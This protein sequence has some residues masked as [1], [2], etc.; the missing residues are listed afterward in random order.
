[1]RSREKYKYTPCYCEE[2][3]WHLC[4]D[5]IGYD[6]KAV[7]ISNEN[8]QCPMWNQR[9]AGGEEPVI[10]DYHVIYLSSI[11]NQ[12]MI[13]DLDTTLEFPSKPEV[14]LSA[15]FPRRI[16]RGY[17]P[18]FRVVEADEF[19]AV[20]SSDREHM[21]LKDGKYSS[22]PPGW[23]FIC[24]GTENNLDRFLDFRDSFVGEIV[25]LGEFK[26]RFSGIHS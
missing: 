7:F 25:N 9:A 26:E 4:N 10:W 24:R 18:V 8:K 12:W 13:L 6:G 2:N 20:F 17:E 22:S 14:Y 3:V 19:I 16:R 1:M 21:V 23:P 5:R 15:S 11:G